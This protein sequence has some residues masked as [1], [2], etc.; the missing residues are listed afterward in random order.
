MKQLNFKM[1]RS[2]IHMFM[3]GIGHGGV[4]DAHAKLYIELWDKVRL[5]LLQGEERGTQ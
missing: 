4:R 1:P 5:R 3:Y 2:R